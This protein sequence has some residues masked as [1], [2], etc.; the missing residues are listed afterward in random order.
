MTKRKT[1]IYKTT[2]KTKDQATRTPLKTG[3]ELGCSGR[4]SSVLTIT[5]VYKYTVMSNRN[6][7]RKKARLVLL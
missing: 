7:N 6:Y 1:T 3:D 2:Q 5:C 4:V